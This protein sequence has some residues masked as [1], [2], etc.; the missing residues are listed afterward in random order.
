MARN[1]YGATSADF[2][3]TSGGRV[4]PGAELTLW[5]AR[6]GGTQITDLL[7]VDSVACT[8]VTSGADGSVVYYG[9][10]S[11]ADTHWADSGQGSR[12]AI[13]PVNITGEP[14]TLEIGT[15]TTGTAD[16]TISGTSPEYTLDFVIPSVAANGVNTA[17]I[18]DSAVT[19]AK[20]ADGT[21]VSGDVA[22]DT[23]AAFGTV[24]NLLSSNVA[25][26]T[27]ALANTTGFT[28]ASGFALA[29][30]TDQALQGT[31]SLKMTTS[32]TGGGG[33]YFGGSSATGTTPI[34][35][36][37][38]YTF[39]AS[40]LA[41]SVTEPVHLRI[42]WWTSAGNVAAS[43]ASFDSP[44]VTTSTDWQEIRLTADAPADAAYASLYV[45]RA[46][47]ANGSVIHVDCPGMWM[48]QGGVFTAPG[49]SVA[50]IQTV[51]AQIADAAVTPDK[52]ANSNYRLITDFTSGWTADHPASTTL[53]SVRGRTLTGATSLEV[54]VSGSNNTQRYI[55]AQC[56]FQPAGATQ[57]MVKLWVDDPSQLTS[58]L[59][60]LGNDLSAWTNCG[61]MELLG[62]GDGEAA[63]SGGLLRRGWNFL[64]VVPSAMTTYASFT[65]DNPIRRLRMAIRTNTD[66]PVRVVFDSVWAMGTNTPRIVFGFD[67]GWATVY[68][69]AFP[70]MDAAGIPG[71]CYIMG[72]Y[73]TENP[74][75]AWFCSTAELLEM[76][77]AGWR[78]ENHSWQHNSY[79]TAGHTPSGYVDLLNQNRDWMLDNGILGGTHINWPQGEYD[80]QVIEAARAAGYRSARAAKC[81]GNHTAEIDNRYK[82]LS[83]N[84]NT[85]VTLGT[86]QTWVERTVESGGIL[87]LQFH[88]IPEDDTTS[89]G[90]ENP[91][92]AWSVD[93]FESLV[94]WLV[95]EGLIDACM[96]H[97]DLVEWAIAAGRAR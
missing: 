50:G 77:A 7:D 85:S 39:V 64:P 25:S 46:S 36:G 71:T 22:A 10:D 28:A 31:R 1:M 34:R 35:G 20:I 56:L 94:D 81:R 47:G 75:S 23:F 54:T 4:I 80:D 86:A 43:T 16:V 48:G 65:M 26:G 12:I 79:L 44:N 62:N 76:Q 13:R 27:D 88:Q 9:P 69:N 74:N 49:M 17:A 89:V 40:V 91:A 93:K 30:S 92:I 63:A 33:V 68:D 14:P 6:T 87:F 5:T 95:N 51:T 55:D 21:I 59:V 3:L 84:F 66:D 70:L 19:S 11:D 96:T 41:P 42:L 29:S 24:G 52:T 32:G 45:R 57:M 8:T 2:T 72:Q 37:E 61:Y 67:D 83:R 38:T 18:Q 73:I 78:H 90:L 82:M 15:V 97:H 53:R 60:Y 58:I